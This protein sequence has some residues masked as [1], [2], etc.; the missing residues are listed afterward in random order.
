VIGKR[1]DHPVPRLGIQAQ[2]TPLSTNKFYANFFLGSQTAPTW[3]HPYSLAWSKGAGTSGSW[4]M[5]IA[6]MDASRKAFGP[7]RSSNPVGYFINPNG[8]Q[9]IVLS[10]AELG[11]S[12]TIT[13]DSLT[14]FSANVNLLPAAGQAPAITFPL[15]QGMGF[16]TGIYKGATP[17]LETGVFFR[18]VTKSLANNLKAGVTKYTIL[19]EDDTTWLVYAY[20]SSGQPLEF[21][22]VKNGLAQATSNFIGTI[23]IAKCPSAAAEALY[24][25]AVGAYPTAVTLS[26]SVSGAQGTYTMSFTKAG[27]TSTS[28]L[29]FALPHH[30]ESFAAGTKSAATG[31]QL[32]TTTKGLA[33][34]VVADSWTLVEPNM[35]IGMGFAPWSP[36]LGDRQAVSAAAMAT[37]QNVATSEISQ[38]MNAQTNLD[39]FYYSGKVSISQR[40]VE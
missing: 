3:T 37:M 5:S 25:A 13:T 40:C 2:N 17:I 14:A 24:D 15:V 10:A 22:V 4:G 16:V 34:A 12:T 28:L 27:L 20:S 19:L 32:Q 26:G 23:Q 39:S 38:D 7:D 35:P 6:H 11:A 29:M 9:F 18:S 21:T 30:V 36:V 1:A 33:T 8:I 31:V